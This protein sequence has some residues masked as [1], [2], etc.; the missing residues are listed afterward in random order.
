M[1]EHYLGVDIRVIADDS[2]A[3]FDQQAAVTQ[4]P[5]LYSAA[6]Q[7]STQHSIESS[8]RIGNVTI[9][10][11]GVRRTARTADVN[12]DKAVCEAIITACIDLIWK[13]SQTLTT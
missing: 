9:E 4:F 13:K 6:E 12:S 5:D 11:D 7:E 10:I 8:R 2:K 1:L 3:E